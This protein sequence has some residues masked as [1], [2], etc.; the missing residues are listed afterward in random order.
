MWFVSDGRTVVFFD[1]YYQRHMTIREHCLNM[2]HK[3]LENQK[4]PCFGIHDYSISYTDHDAQA[5]AEIAAATDEDNK[6][7]GFDCVPADKKVMEGILLV[8]TMI[9][10]HRLFITTRCVEARKEI[11]SYR[12]RP[13]EGNK[14]CVDE[15]PIKEHD[16]CADAVRMA[17]ASE[18]HSSNP[19]ARPDSLRYDFT[20]L[21]PDQ[22][23]EGL[24]GLVR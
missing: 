4:L 1:E 21:A 10:E 2:R 14:K 22:G 12:A 23:L 19:F 20:R 3:E 11:P 17:C 15:K 18:M 16:D 6:A 24:E 13:M 8:Q 9:R 5:R 7:I